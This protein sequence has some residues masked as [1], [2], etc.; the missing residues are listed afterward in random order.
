MFNPYSNPECHSTQ[1]YRQVA[2]SMYH[3]NTVAD[4][5]TTSLQHSAV[6]SAKINNSF[7]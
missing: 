4:H 3:A 5:T 6:R 1:N 2:V 7:K